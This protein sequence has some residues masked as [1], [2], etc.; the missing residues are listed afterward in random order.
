MTI[1]LL[2]IF[3]LL[4]L[5]KP[6]FADGDQPAPAAETEVIVLEEAPPGDDATEQEKADYWEGVRLQYEAAKA[7]SKA[8][9]DKTKDAAGDAYDKTKQVAGDAY[10]KTKDMAGD[11]YESTRD[12]T[13]GWYEG[14]RD[15]TEEDIKK[16]G[17]WQYRVVVIEKHDIRYEREKVEAMLNELGAE[18]FECYWV[19][20]LDDRNERMA[21]FFKKSG[22]SYL[23]SIPAGELWRFIPTGNGDG[24]SGN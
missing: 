17:A 11:A 16:A 8:L 18:R 19:E 15:W 21:F 4:P 13:V 9:M 23:K 2:C 7:K 6:L 22:F 3:L 14:A 10:S 12:A 20:P 5:S 1:R 24:D